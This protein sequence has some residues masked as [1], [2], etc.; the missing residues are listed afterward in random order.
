MWHR[1]HK[2]ITATM[3]SPNKNEA[4]EAVTTAEAHKSKVWS[5]SNSPP[6]IKSM[7]TAT[8]EATKPT[9]MPWHWTNAKLLITNEMQ[10]SLRSKF[11]KL[12][13]KKIKEN[14]HC[15]KAMKSSPLLGPFGD[16]EFWEFS[17]LKI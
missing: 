17:L 1:R 15:I 4:I 10:S 7:I 9:T 16:S 13:W 11:P 2:I 8:I 14:V 6:F 12:A 5:R 3:T